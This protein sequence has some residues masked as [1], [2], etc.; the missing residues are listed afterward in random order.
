VGGPGTAD[1][2]TQGDDGVGKIEERVDDVLVA[3]VAALE[4]VEGVVPGIRAFYMSTLTGLDRGL[5]ALMGDRAGHFPS[6]EFIAGFRRV[7]AGV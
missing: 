4:P 3:F 1:Q 5:V 6:C 7:V 2:A